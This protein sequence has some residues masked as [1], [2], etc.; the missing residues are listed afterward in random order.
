MIGSLFSRGRLAKDSQED[1]F[2]GTPAS[3]DVEDLTSLFRRLRQNEQRLDAAKLKEM[4][5]ACHERLELSGAVEQ[6][7][8]GQV[9]RR[10]LKPYVMPVVAFG[11]GLGAL[12]MVTGSEGGAA[13]PLQMLTWWSTRPEEADCRYEVLTGSAKASEWMNDGALINGGNDVRRTADEEAL[14]EAPRVASSEPM[15]RASEA[16]KRPVLSR[17]PRTPNLNSENPSQSRPAATSLAGESTMPV[18]LAGM[19]FPNGDTMHRADAL[20][21]EDDFAKQVRALKLADQA[22]KV[23]RT[24][25]ARDALARKFAPTLAPHADALRVVLACQGGEP[26]VGRRLL[27]AHARQSP[28]SPYLPR[29]R[30]ACGVEQ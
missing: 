1:E 25:E 30:R 28:N 21:P 18:P 4:A 16:H 19:R 12:F 7:K 5:D 10:S 24:N 23:H 9:L 22:L 17:V 6:W 3:E 20:H 11:V 8:N 14:R 2:D 27:H 26:Q 13:E 15:H 29:L